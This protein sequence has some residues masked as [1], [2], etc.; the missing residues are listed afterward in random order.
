MSFPRCAQNKSTYPN[1][2]GS[3]GSGGTQPGKVSGLSNW[4]RHWWDV[5]EWVV[6]A[7]V[8]QLCHLWVGR[9]WRRQAVEV[10]PRGDR[11]LRFS[12]LSKGEAYSSAVDS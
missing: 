10:R 9:W 3:S 6:K 12:S 4:I 2:F 11:A 1:F 7:S 8:L 5:E